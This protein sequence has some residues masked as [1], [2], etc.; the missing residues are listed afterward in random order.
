MGPMEMLVHV[1]VIYD[2]RPP[3]PGLQGLLPSE[4]V[5]KRVGFESDFS[6][7]NETLCQREGQKILDV[8]LDAVMGCNHRVRILGIQV[9]GL[10]YKPPQQV[11]VAL[12]SPQA[13]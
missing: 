2:K 4:V 3:I 1:E 12:K 8:A 5:V 7:S 6:E 13:A 11:F 10:M 9:D